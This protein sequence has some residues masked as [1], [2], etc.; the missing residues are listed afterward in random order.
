MKFESGTAK[1]DLFDQP[2]RRRVVRLAREGKVHRDRVG[3]AHHRLDIRP[4]RRAR[5]RFRTRRRSRT[6]SDQRRL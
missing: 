4:R 5:R 3:R 2:V 6:S 1:R